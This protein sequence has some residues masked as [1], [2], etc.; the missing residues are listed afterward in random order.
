MS[1]QSSLPI[2]RSK[3]SKKSITQS[4]HRSYG[5]KGKKKNKTTNVVVVEIDG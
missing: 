1:L 2:K 4:Q 3:S 5:R